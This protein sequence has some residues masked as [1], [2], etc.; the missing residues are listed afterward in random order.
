MKGGK[1]FLINMEEKRV[2]NRQMFLEMTE[3]RNLSLVITKTIKT[4]E[5]EIVCCYRCK[6]SCRNPV[7][8]NQCYT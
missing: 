6:N 2:K 5:V 7:D 4:I 8:K 3:V 1:L